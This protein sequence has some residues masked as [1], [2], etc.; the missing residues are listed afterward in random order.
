MNEKETKQELERVLREDSNNYSKILELSTRLSSFDNDNIRFSVDAGVID[1]LGS[2]LVARQETAV[3]ELVKNSYDADATQVNIRFE[4][5]DNIGGTLYIEDNGTGMTREQLANGFM[6]ISSTDK[7]HNPVSKK[8]KRT[9][10][11][12]KGIGR[13]AVQRLGEKLTIITQTEEN[14]EA[15]VVNI[16]W[17]DYSS[18]TDLLSINNRIETLSQ[19]KQSHGTILKIEGLKDRWSE[20]SIRRIYKYVGDIL[21]PFPLSEINENVENTNIDPGF[22]V[23]FSKV[24]NNKQINIADDKTMVYNHATAIIEGSVDE[25]GFGLYSVESKKLEVNEIGEISSDPD[26]KNIPFSELRNIKFRAYYFVYNSGYISKMQ[27]SSIRKLARTQGG[28]RLYRNGFR[29]LPY[30]EPNNDWLGLDSS[31]VKRSILP[32]HANINFFGFVELADRNREF[33]ETSSREG[34]VENEA[35]IQLKN[36]V[37]RTIM[38]AVIKIAEVR[39][40]KIVSGQKEIDGIYEAMDVRIKNIAF[41]I[42]ELDRELENDS[43]SVEVKRKRK[44]T[45]QKVK[46]ELEELQKAQ[47]EE[48]EL[49]LKEK[50]ML[51]VLSSVGL[52]IALFIHEVR[53]YILNMN[54]DI[55]FLLEKLK[56]EEQIFR[57][58]LMLQ[59]NVETFQ[60]YTSYFD[61]VIS[62]NVVRSLKPIELQNTIEK[63]WKNIQ[64][65]A[66]KSNIEFEKPI[67]N[68]YYLFTTPMHPSEWSSI[69][70]NLYTNAKKAIKRSKNKGIIDIECGKIDN[71]IFLRFSDTGDGISDNIKDRIFEEFFTTSSPNTLDNLNSSNEITGTG[72]GLK[73]VK[74]ILSSYRGR[75]YV[76]T[77]KEG[78]STTIYLEIPKATDKDLDKYGL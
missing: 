14:T 51:R 67:R 35:F 41:T 16:N 34:L 75:I 28:I 8:F 12:Q 44:K 55:S 36:F 40:I 31:T 20:A 39:N 46:K 52:T 49:N 56:S 43:S 66:K 69:L 23:Y 2:E 4:N 60:S 72:L 5:S 33:N 27:E 47:K 53:E 64:N 7:L 74:D 15:L 42:E 13:F 37:Y 57:R 65:D 59:S 77:P 29:V 58:L 3:S 73:I 25:N 76:D 19:K 17:N 63:F 30:G 71:R 24:I 70:F 21:Q 48:K 50:A 6:R 10:A 68:G 54:S 38:T 32:V 61:A 78:F 18:D 26:N 62:Q 45:I 9:R 11:G 22:K 1:R